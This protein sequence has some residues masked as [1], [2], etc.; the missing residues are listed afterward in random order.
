VYKQKLVEEVDSQCQKGKLAEPISLGQIKGK[1]HFQACLY[2]GHRPNPAVGM[3]LPVL[4][5]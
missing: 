5:S 1:P 3:S 4:G 2:E